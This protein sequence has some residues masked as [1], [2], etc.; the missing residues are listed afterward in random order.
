MT[1]RSIR[2]STVGGATDPIGEINGGSALA[3]KLD[4]PDLFFALKFK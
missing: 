1:G 3:Q 4:S 2:I